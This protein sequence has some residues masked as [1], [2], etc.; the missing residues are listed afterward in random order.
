MCCAFVNAP[1]RRAVSR[2]FGKRGVGMRP[3]M[4]LIERDHA[5]AGRAAMTV[6]GIPRCCHLRPWTRTGQ[7]RRPCTG[8]RTRTAPTCH[9]RL[10]AG[11]RTLHNAR[12][13]RWQGATPFRR[14]LLADP[15]QGTHSRGAPP[16]RSCGE[17][18]HLPHSARS[19]RRSISSGAVPSRRTRARAPG[20]KRAFSSQLSWHV[21]C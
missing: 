6:C 13:S 20:R 17:H 18:T 11:H 7:P 8:V 9:L 10:E 19:L 15:I 21:A 5:R 3:L 16:G 14:R 12:S 4:P 2:P 1:S